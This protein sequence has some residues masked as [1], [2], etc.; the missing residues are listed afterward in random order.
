MTVDVSAVAR[1]L[2]LTPEQRDLL[3]RANDRS[4]PAE[5]VARVKRIRA[6]IRAF[7]S[8]SYCYPEGMN[9]RPR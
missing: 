5:R 3:A 6:H 1:K 9:D 7:P 8:T 4:S 2:G